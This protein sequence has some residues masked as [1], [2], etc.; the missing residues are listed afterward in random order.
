MNTLKRKNNFSN[1][2]L[3]DITLNMNSVKI[4]NNYAIIYSRIS[5]SRQQNGTSLESQKILCQDYCKLLNFNVINSI[6]EIC[7]ATQMSKQNKLNNIIMNNTNIN[8]VILEPSRLCRNI[9]D[10]TILLNKCN[11]KNIIIHFAQTNMTSNNSQ[12]IKKMISCVYDAEHESKTLSQRV[13]RSISYRKYMKI[14]L[15][16]IPSFGFIIK[17]KKLC[18]S[19]EEQN[20]ISLINK[21]YFGSDTHSINELLYKITGTHDEICDLYDDDEI[22][23]VKYGNMLIIDIVSFLN[24]LG[25]TCRKKKWYSQSVSKLIK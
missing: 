25:I 4:N 2:T 11:E 23:E 24:N 12:D 1:A 21:L 17:N 14:Y 13:K 18:T 19:P 6:E 16:S 5:T 3:N 9:K 20:I 15:P 10:F 22:L 7:S 8:I